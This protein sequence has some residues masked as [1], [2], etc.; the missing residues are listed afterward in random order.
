VMGWAAA[1]PRNVAPSIAGMS[2]GASF[3]QTYAPGMLLSVFGSQL[4]IFTAAAS[5]VPLPASLAGVSATVNGVVAPLYYVSPGQINLEVP[6]SLAAGTAVV[7]INN[8]GHTVSASIT[9]AAAAPGIFASAMPASAK[10]GD[11]LTLYLT[12]AGNAL[13]TLMVTVGGVRAAIS[14]AAVPPGLAGVVQVNYQ[15]P[16][17]APLGSQPVVVSVSGVPS[18]PVNLT[19]TQ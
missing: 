12:G 5:S 10:R 9:L 6:D 14:Y 2:N 1:A 13:Q 11:I 7:A 4:S 15:V 8:N 17:Q 3:R 19:L 16:A 18:P